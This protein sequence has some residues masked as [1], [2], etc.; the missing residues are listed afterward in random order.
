MSQTS[1]ATLTRDYE[2]LRAEVVAKD[3]V[4]EELKAR[5]A[6]LVD[7]DQLIAQLRCQIAQLNG[8]LNTDSHNSSKP[9]SS[10]G[11]AKPAPRL[12]TACI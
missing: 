11:Y 8:R 7:Q 10:D 4:I 3:E 6:D 12:P 2:A 5:I 1:Y 9:P